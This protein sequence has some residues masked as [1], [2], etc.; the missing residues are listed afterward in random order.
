MKKPS[1]KHGVYLIILLGIVIYRYSNLFTPSNDNKEFEI[2]V[3]DELRSKRLIYTKHAE[4][5]M[6]CRFISEEEIAEALRSGQINYQKSDL[7]DTPCP[8]YAVE[9]NTPDGQRVRIVFADCDDV[10]KVVT[11]IDLNGE[12]SCHCK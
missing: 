9:D 8:T 11:A 3:L 12:Y 7:N 10:V 4:C 1:I 6:D 2:T 5:R